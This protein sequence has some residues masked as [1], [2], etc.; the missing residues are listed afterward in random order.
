K[1]HSGWTRKQRQ[2]IV[3]AAME[4]GLNVTA[5]YPASNYVG[6][7]NLST[8]TDGATTSEHEFS[9]VGGGQSDSVRFIAQSGTTINF[10]PL[11]TRGGYAS[12]YWKTLM[13]DPRLRRFHVG[14]TPQ[15][16]SRSQASLTGE[17]LPP[18]R[19]AAEDNARLVAAIAH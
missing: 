5:H 1:Y 11:A 18:L 3:A 10:S 7:F 15:Q 13:R 2:W 17:V 16:D 4:T 9:E 6:R 19:P 14:S 8:I 12:R